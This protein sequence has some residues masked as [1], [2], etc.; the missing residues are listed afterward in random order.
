VRRLSCPNA[1]DRSR[2]RAGSIAA[3]LSWC[4]RHVETLQLPVFCPRLWTLA[5]GASSPFEFGTLGLV[6]GVCCCAGGADG[7]LEVIKRLS[8]GAVLLFVVVL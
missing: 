5:L 4:R 8:C 1:P 6:A 7:F 2:A 3:G